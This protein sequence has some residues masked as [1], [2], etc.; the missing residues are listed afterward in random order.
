MESNIFS[1]TELL[2]RLRLLILA[3][4]DA[5]AMEACAVAAGR[6]PA[7]QICCVP[8]HQLLCE[9]TLAGSLESHQWACQRRGVQAAQVNTGLPLLR[10]QPLMQT[11]MSPTVSERLVLT[12]KLLI[13]VPSNAVGSSALFSSSRPPDFA[14]EDKRISHAPHL[15][16]PHPARPGI[17]TRLFSQDRLSD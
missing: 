17:V 8:T 7:H 1:Y 15:P 4:L 11:A 3:R 10:R 5:C 14:G 9:I 2:A 16:P 13:G 12:M 6:E